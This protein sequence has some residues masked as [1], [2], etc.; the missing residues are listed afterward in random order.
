MNETRQILSQHLSRIGASS[1]HTLSISSFS[2]TSINELLETVLSTTKSSEQVVDTLLDLAE[3]AFESDVNFALNIAHSALSFARSINSNKLIARAMVRAGKYYAFLPDVRRAIE[4]LHDSLELLPTDSEEQVRGEAFMF[5]GVVYG[6]LGDYEYSLNLLEQAVAIFRASALVDELSIG[7]YHIG[8]VHASVARYDE[9]VHYLLLAFNQASARNLSSIMVSSML[10]V[11]NIFAKIGDEKQAIEYYTICRDIHIS[12]GNRLA[13]AQLE[14]M[15]GIIAISAH[16]FDDA[17]QSQQKALHIYEELG[18]QAEAAESYRYIGDLKKVLGQYPEAL[19]Q[20][21]RGISLAEKS[22]A[23]RALALLHRSIGQTHRLLGHFLDAVEF[24]EKSII[25]AQDTS[26]QGLLYEIYEDLSMVFEEMGNYEHALEYFKQAS[27]I[28]GKIFN[29]QKQTVI[30]HLHIRFATEQ[31]IRRR[32]LVEKEREILLLRTNE[33]SETL[34][35]LR[36]LNQEKD[37]FLA[38]AAH[39]LRTPLT[40][41]VLST[42]IIKTFWAKMAKE[43]LEEQIDGILSRT[44]RMN[45]IINNLLEIS[46]IE[47]G[48]VNLQPQEFNIASMTETI[49]DEFRAIAQEKLIQLHFMPVIGSNFFVK[50]NANATIEM[51]ENYLSNAIKF[52]PPERSIFVAVKEFEKTVC[53]SVQDQGPGL[54]EQDMKKVFKKFAKL[55]ARPTGNERSHGLGLSIV[56]RLAELMGGRAWCE[57]VF[58]NGATFF[59]ELPKISL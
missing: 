59:V 19:E 17:L 31:N 22:Q 42:S 40:G 50:A 29:E 38:I 46:K 15:R 6:I 44:T 37:E 54:T 10:A 2:E 24:L 48:K 58:G 52:S 36:T 8:S 30:A 28:K 12:T 25:F 55:S 3:Q 11:A 21:Q 4:Y 26:S 14:N 34:E 35:Q 23:H 20:Y 7:F 18:M 43:D 45:E 57:S 47:S 5:L 56:K 49:T 41:I 13:E 51:I 39:D 32:E 33:L 1:P 53:V 9:A 16:Q 27:L